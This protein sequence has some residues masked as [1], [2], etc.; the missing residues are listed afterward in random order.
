MTRITQFGFPTRTVPE[1]RFEELVTPTSGFTDSPPIFADPASFYSGQNV[2]IKNGEMFPRSRLSTVGTESLGGEPNGFFLYDD[3]SGGATPVVTSQD[4]VAY[5]QSQSFTSLTYISGTS[6]L[7]PTGGATDEYFGTSVYLERSD[8][9]LA[10]FTNGLEPLFAWEGPSITTG[11][12]TL[13]QAPIATDVAL[14]DN[15]LIGWNI[16]ELSSNSRLVQRVQ[17][18]VSGDSEDW[19][20]IGSGFEDLVDMR[21]VGTRIFAAEDRLIL[22]SD[23]EVW[24]GRRIGLPFIFRFSPIDKT[25][26]MPFRRAALQTQRGIFW[27]NDDFNIYRVVGGRITPIG[28]AIKQVLR[29][30]LV[31]PEEAFF[32]FNEQQGL[33]TLYYTITAGT[34][35]QRAFSLDIVEGHWT[36]HTFTQELALSG[37][38]VVSSSATTWGGLTGNLSAQNLTFNQ[39]LGITGAN[40]EAV[41]S[42]NG[43]PYIFH[44]EATNDDG[45]VVEEDAYF[46]GLFKE[47]ATSVKFLNEVKLDVSADSASTLSVG[48][49]SNL[50]ETFDEEVQ[51]S[52]SASSTYTQAQVNFNTLSG[53]NPSLRIRSDDGSRWKVA[54]IYAKA[55]KKGRS[56]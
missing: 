53:V 35:P 3:I 19:T 38:A 43:T 40:E 27:L 23:K 21:G 24:Q 54:R 16:Q 52:I 51:L 11:F 10:I 29:N 5:L 42:S 47:D 25:I 14:F 32:G 33:L 18:S 12:S 8:I 7:P 1:R 30:E 55:V 46:G 2:W 31:A 41:F 34:L 28:D 13:T 4:T 36:P 6:N 37:S 15:K 50:G 17:W 9:N 49:S 56:F 39:F 44:S 20:G 48:G 45:S 26:G 22:A